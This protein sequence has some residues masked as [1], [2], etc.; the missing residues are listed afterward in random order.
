MVLQNVVRDGRVRRGVGIGGVRFL[1]ETMYW[2]C[3]WKELLEQSH[4][5]MLKVSF[6]YVQLYPFE[7]WVRK[8]KGL[9]DESS[10]NY[11]MTIAIN[12]TREAR[13]SI[14]I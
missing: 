4:L 14:S 12:T 13:L 11:S 9:L 5:N 6:D 8:G 3:G 10:Q 1:C 7:H 2:I